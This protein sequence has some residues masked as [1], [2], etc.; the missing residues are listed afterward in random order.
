MHEPRL[1]LG[2][3]QLGMNYGIAN[4]EGRP[5]PATAKVMVQTAWEGGVRTFDTAAAYGQ[6]E[7]VL[8]QALVG[9]GLTPQAQV[10]SKT[11]PAW[12]G[13][14]CAKVAETTARSLRHL[15]VETLHA[16]L[17][18]RENLIGQWDQGVGEALLGEVRAGR[19]QSVGVSVYT[20]ATALT[21]L[22]IPGISLVQL[23]ANLLDRRFETAGVFELAARL[24]KTIH[25]RS[26]HLQGL[27]LMAPEDIPE[28]MAFARETIG[29]AQTLAA[30]Y[31]LDPLQAGWAFMG[32]VCPQAQLIFGADNP[33]QLHANL[34]AART[35]CPP[36]F[37]RAVRQAFPSVPERILNPAL[38][39][40]Q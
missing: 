40:A 19:T 12:D 21:A 36:G 24:G 2:T 29:Q 37:V 38:W 27:L 33:G 6:S 3:A 18:H 15:G 20:P 32:E 4:R 5:D 22:G 1:V 28:R 13:L 9:L 14:D 7:A 11:D 31:G 10:V 39:E 35:P 17:L 23:P 25:V 16:L 30:A 34:Q 8:G 26:L